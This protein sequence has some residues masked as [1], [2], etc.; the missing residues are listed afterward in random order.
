MKE[1]LT[2]A[3]DYDIKNAKFVAFTITNSYFKQIIHV[4]KR[5]NYS[6]HWSCG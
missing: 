4:T 1:G 6:G 2:R 5:K 3:Y